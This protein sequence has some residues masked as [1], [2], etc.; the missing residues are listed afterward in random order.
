MAESCQSMD[1]LLPLHLPLSPSS[2]SYLRVQPLVTLPS[3][4]GQAPPDAKAQSKSTKGAE[5]TPRNTRV[6]TEPREP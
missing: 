5:Q 1:H 4:K 2:G 3:E 6:R